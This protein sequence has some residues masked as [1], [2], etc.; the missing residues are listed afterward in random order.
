MVPP[1]DSPLRPIRPLADGSLRA[2]RAAAEGD[3]SAVLAAAKAG[4]EWALAILYRRH[5]PAIGRYL[6]AKAGQ[7]ADD[8]A[9]QTWLDAARNLAGFDGDE[10]AFRGW[11]FTI[12]RRRLIDHGRRRTRRPEVLTDRTHELDDGPAADAADLAVDALSGED[13]ARRIIELLPPDQA[14]IVLLRV[15]AGLDVETVASV[16]GKRPGT[17]RVAQHRALKRLA[18][19]LADD[20][21]EV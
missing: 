2:S 21:S 13:A 17:V 3:F 6:R 5:D 20:V 14:D 11:L 12:A 10:D 18:A 19:T 8:L 7:D 1:A 15:V 9:S 16:T 4:G